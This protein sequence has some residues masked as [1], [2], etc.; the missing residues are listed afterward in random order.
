MEQENTIGLTDL[1]AVVIRGWKRIGISMLVFAFLLGGYQI[2]R[3]VSLAKDP[4]NFPEEIEERYEV[5]MADYEKELDSLQRSL[6]NQKKFLT[7]KEEYLEKSFLFQIDPYNK[8]TA[9]IVFTFSDIDESAQLFRY[10]NTAADYLPKK[11]RSQYIALWESIDV[12]RDIGLP[13]YKDVEWKYLSEL[14]SVSALEGELVSIQTV[15]TTMSDAE[16]LADAVYDYFVSYQDTIGAG[17]AWHH[18]LLM[19]RTTQTVIDEELDIKRENLETEIENLRTDIEKSE[20]AIEN[21]KVPSRETGYS[22]V[23]IIKAVAKYA[24]L[25]AM[26]GAFLACAFVCCRWIFSNRIVHSFQLEAAAAAPFLGSLRISDAWSER[27][28]IRVMGERSWNDK[29][30]A[31]SYI[32]QQAKLCFPE[33]KM[34]LLLSAMPEELAGTKIKD[35]GKLLSDSGLQTASA[36]DAIHNPHAVELIRDCAAVVLVESPGYSSVTAVQSMAAQIKSWKKPIL[37]VITI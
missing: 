6:E 19:N 34:V 20:Q 14:V 15:G 31:A 27:L 23:E 16:Q 26:V 9:N 12:P 22:T 37:G 11:I 2:Y 32:S 25:G 30:Q 17:S 21:L 5:A 35:L 13:Q 1:L 28:A 3:Q 33:N 29:N 10:P 7:S 18:I 24:V 8:Y 4:S 36:V